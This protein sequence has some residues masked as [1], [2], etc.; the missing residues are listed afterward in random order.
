ME[1]GIHCSVREG[2]TLAADEAAAH[3]CRAFQML[4]YRRHHP[5]AESELASFR[6]KKKALGLSRVLVHS[7][8]VPFLGSMDAKRHE[9]SVALLA[10]ELSWAKGLEAEAYVL[11]A[12]A[13]SE[14]SSAEEGIKRVSAGIAEACRRV[15]GAPNILIENVTGGGR[16]LGGS[17]EEVAAVMNGARER[18]AAAGACLDTA[19]AWA[20]GYDIASAEGMLKWLGRVH[21]IIGADAVG[22]FHLNDSM[23]L[24]G[25]RVESHWHWGEGRLG[26]EG[27]KALLARQE[28]AGA[29][30][31]LETPKDPG[32]DARN[33]KLARGLAGAE[34]SY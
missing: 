22:A 28:Y 12:G 15:E 6:A 1:L 26:L 25:S 5:P 2:L 9:H 27:L 19:H 14:G 21:R 30:G 11:H 24:L 34:Y 17:L 13:F 18:G 33:L 3:S 29:I 10:Q 20:A 4:P 23:A 32:A 16:R 8:F 7:R 31:I